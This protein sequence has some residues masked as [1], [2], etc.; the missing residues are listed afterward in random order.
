MTSIEQIPLIPKDMDLIDVLWKQDIDMGVC[1]EIFDGTYRQKELEKEKLLELERQKEEDKVDE[2]AG[3]EYMVDGETGEYIPVTSQTVTVDRPT[4]QNGI[5]LDSEA[6]DYNLEECI[7][8]LR[9]HARQQNPSTTSTCSDDDIGDMDSTASSSPVSTHDLEQQWQD[10]ASLPELQ[11]L[12]TETLDNTFATPQGVNNTYAMNATT[13]GDVSLQ[14]ATV[15][16]ETNNLTGLLQSSLSSPTSTFANLRISSPSNS[17]SSNFSM[18][19]PDSADNVNITFGVNAGSNANNDSLLAALVND[20]MF[21]EIGMMDLAMDEGLE[22]L[23]QLEDL[24]KADDKDSA[25]SVNSGSHAGSVSDWNETVSISSV[26]PEGSS[27]DDGIDGDDLSDDML[28]ATSTDY[29]TGK[30]SLKQESQYEKYQRYST[31]PPSMEHIKHNHTY[32]QPSESEQKHEKKR[33]NGGSHPHANRPDS[34]KRDKRS[35][36]LSRDEKRAKT[37]SI[38]FSTNEIIDLPVDEFNELM[39]K[40]QLTEPQL[41]LIRD[42]RRRGKNKVAAQHCR[43]RKLDAISAIEDEVNQ[44]K[45]EKEKLRKE[46]FMIDKEG[47]EMKDRFQCLYREVFESLRDESGLPYDPQQYSLQ[48]STDGN[49]FLV[50][51]GKNT[52]EQKN[53][54][55]KKKNS[56][57]K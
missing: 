17:L 51:N 50:P 37:L 4:T 7:Q 3:I 10:I 57:S 8:M 42:I 48:Q 18:E 44:L 16:S 9:E 45:A 20:A 41:A 2:W 13:N 53:K 40:Y 28:G 31:Q 15:P 12:N 24:E 55:G 46:R 43:K 21:E 22:S 38:P 1:R 47:R 49:V 32:P 52:K 29:M 26:Q 23:T 25:V 36:K 54:N 11:H 6:I 56:A 30:K 19:F 39:S 35:E 33:N 14:N 27:D 5:N 34:S